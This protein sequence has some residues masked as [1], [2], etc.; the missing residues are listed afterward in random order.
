MIKLKMSTKFAYFLQ[1]NKNFFK[2]VLTKKNH[3][4]R[5]KI[6]YAVKLC[7][8]VFFRG[9]GGKSKDKIIDYVNNLIV[10]MVLF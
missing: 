2:K 4:D 7:V 3:C 5:L 6:T 9:N 1:K 8:L 10:L